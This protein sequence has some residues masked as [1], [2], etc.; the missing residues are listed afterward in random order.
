MGPEAK[1]QSDCRKHAKKLGWWAR[2]FSSP[3]QRGVTDFLFAKVSAFLGPQKIAVEFKAPG[4]TSTPL[5]MHE[6]ELMRQAGWDVY[7]CDNLE[8]FKEILRR[9]D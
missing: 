4:E 9:H 2:K 8:Y 7:E 3:S 6:Q 5:Q 1:V